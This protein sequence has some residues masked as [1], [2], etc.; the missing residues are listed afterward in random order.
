MV[1]LIHHNTT[2]HNSVPVMSLPYPMDSVPLSHLTI[3]LS[4]TTIFNHGI[5]ILISSSLFPSSPTQIYT[6]SSQKI[7]I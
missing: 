2:Q 6:H 1:L 4:V 5:R 3:L 7:R